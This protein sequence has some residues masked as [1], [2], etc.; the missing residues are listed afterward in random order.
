MKDEKIILRVRPGRVRGAIYFSR[1]GC[2]SF[3][4][5]E[6]DSEQKC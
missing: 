5:A 4:C 3:K 2:I 1:T 6:L